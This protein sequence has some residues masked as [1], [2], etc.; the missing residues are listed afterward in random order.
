MEK[1]SPIIDELLE[2]YISELGLG[3][4]STRIIEV[5]HETPAKKVFDLLVYDPAKHARLQVFRSERIPDLYPVDTDADG[6]PD[7]RDN[8]MLVPNGPLIPGDASTSQQDSDGDHTGDACD[9]DDGTGT[10]DKAAGMQGRH[11]AV[12]QGIAMP[13][14]L[15][16]S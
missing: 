14:A 16:A 3:E 2:K 12:R 15:P 11:P 7:Y 5:T 4:V 9:T 6:I 10:S 1:I 8:C 13:A